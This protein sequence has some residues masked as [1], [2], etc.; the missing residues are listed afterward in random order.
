M[1]ATFA[2]VDLDTNLPRIITLVWVRNLRFECVIVESNGLTYSQ[3]AVQDTG[4]AGLDTTM[5]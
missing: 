5:Q 2:T 3:R 1:E 4:Q